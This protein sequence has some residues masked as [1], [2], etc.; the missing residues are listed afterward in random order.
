V[1]PERPS[2]VEL[3]GWREPVELLQA[4]RGRRRVA[5]LWS[6]G[7][8]A[9]LAR[10]HVLVAD[11]YLTFRWGDGRAVVEDASGEVSIAVRDPLAHL[12]ALLGRGPSA[13]HPPWPFASGAVG[14]I[15]YDAARGIERL[16]SIAADD[17]PHA[18]I[19]FSLYDWA[20]NWDRALGKWCVLASGAPGRDR[21]DRIA[22]AEAVCAREARWAA[23]IPPASPR[24]PRRA[25]GSSVGLRASLDR[26]AYLD[27]V[28]TI[29]RRIERGECYE[30]NL[31][32]RLT[33]REKVDPRDLFAALSVANPAPFASF[34]EIASGALVG[35]SPERFLSVHDGVAESRPIKGT[36]G[37]RA[38]DLE[39]RA[40]AARLSGSP[41]DRAENIMIVDLVRNDLG[42]VSRP[43]SIEVAALCAVESFAGVHHLVS[44]VRGRLDPGR[45][46]LD[47]ARA[48]FPPGSMTGAPKIRAMEVIESIEP[49]RRGPYAGAAGYFSSSGEADLSVVIRTF[50]LSPEAIDLQVGGAVVADSDPAGEFD[51]AA[52]KG[53]RALVALAETLGRPLSI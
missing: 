53:E 28:S 33:V 45:S 43:G 52:V 29:K 41:K 30:V 7:G 14:F 13:P 18:Q 23:S 6:G 19:E 44:T 24:A 51:E 5:L 36:L 48:L 22:G 11:P 4:S 47:A 27:A 12:A 39:D 10:F 40:Q 21:L 32:R 37:R 1:S 35:S 8:D 2:I 15:G 42:R 31:S 9:S 26:D 25:P 16:P 46:A 20:V 49:V 34:I 38:G 17:R 50:V 3:P